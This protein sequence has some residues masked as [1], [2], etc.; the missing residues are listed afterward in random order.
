MHSGKKSLKD[1]IKRMK[2]SMKDL[3]KPE[4][5][6][7]KGGKLVIKTKRKLSP[8]LCMACKKDAG[9]NFVFIYKTNHELKGKMCTICHIEMQEEKR[10]KE[11][12]K[13]MN[14]EF[15]PIK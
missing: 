4:K 7:I 15:K 9:K 12:E 10:K 11:N 3:Q 13:I 6:V 1:E 8:N 2:A 5:G 14:E